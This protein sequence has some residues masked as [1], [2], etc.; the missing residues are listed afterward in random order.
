MQSI[1]VTAATGRDPWGS[2]EDSW[3]LID[4]LPLEI[5]H[6]GQAIRSML[7]VRARELLTP[8]VQHCAA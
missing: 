4:V 2:D 5:D 1:R 6:P 8:A 3:T 7:A